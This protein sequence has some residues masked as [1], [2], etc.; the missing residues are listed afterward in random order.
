MS[1]ESLEGLKHGNFPDSFKEARVKALYKRNGSRKKTNNYRPISVLSNVSKIFEKLI[2]NRLYRFLSDNDLISPNQFGFLPRSNT[3]T[4]TL[5]AISKIKESL[6]RK[7]LTAATFIDISKAFDSVEH[8]TLLQK[9]ENYGIRGKCNLLVQN[10]LIG[11]GQ[12]V[13]TTK[14]S[15]DFGAIEFG[16]P[17]GSSLS[18]LLFLIYINGCLSLQ[19]SGYLQMYADDAI[20]IY[21]SDEYSQLQLDMQN[22]LVKIDAWLYNN[23]LSFNPDKTKFMLFR[24]SLLT[25]HE[26]LNIQVDG[27]NIERISSTK[28]LG[29]IIDEDLKWKHHIKHLRNTLNPYLFILRRSRYMLPPQTKLSLYY[30]YIHSHLS[31][32][33]SIW[34]YTTEDQ[35][36]QLQILQNKTIRSLFWQEYTNGTDTETLLRTHNIPNVRQL[37]EIDSMLLIHKISH[38]QIKNN[39]TLRRFTSQHDYNTRNRDNYI[40]P[41]ARTN[42]LHNSLLFRGL[43]LYN[44]LPTELKQTENTSTFKK[45]IKQRVLSSDDLT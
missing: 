10:Y 22:D 45:C 21:S 44:S 43:L 3:T 15:S 34:G 35:I 13:A 31:Y 23:F 36:N 8:Y 4:A 29:L 27:T 14:H 33:I 28:Y 40:L 42:I 18:S 2:Y 5:H 38:G 7:L 32:L 19:I 16:I 37:R 12:T 17:Q 20:V 30:S 39:I 24:S 11:R 26:P 9:L 1:N 41:R 6:D 25:N